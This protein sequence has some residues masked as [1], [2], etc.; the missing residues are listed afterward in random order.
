MLYFTSFGG[1]YSGQADPKGGYRVDGW[2]YLGGSQ[3]A[4]R[5]YQRTSTF[6]API[7][8]GAPGDA[9]VTASENTTYLLRHTPE[10]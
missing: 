2:S 1:L 6:S 4:K 9:A 5:D 8:E 7:Y 10:R 3:W